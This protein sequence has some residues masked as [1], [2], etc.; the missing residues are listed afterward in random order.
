MQTAGCRRLAALI[1]QLPADSALAHHAE[2]SWTVRDELAAANLEVQ[3]ASWLQLRALTGDK[4]VRNATPLR[5]PRPGQ[6]TPSTPV[7]RV[8]MNDLIGG[9]D[10]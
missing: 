6:A 10:P 5:V 8:S 9:G 3:H 4:T 2:Q 1:F 7:R